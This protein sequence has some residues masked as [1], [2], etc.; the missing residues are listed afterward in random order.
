MKSKLILYRA[1]GYFSGEKLNEKTCVGDGVVFFESEERAFEQVGATGGKIGK[2]D[3]FSLNRSTLGALDLTE[4]DKIL[5]LIALA[6]KF[7]PLGTDS[8]FAMK[9]RGY[10]LDNYLTEVSGYDVIRCY[11]PSALMTF[12]DEFIDGEVSLEVLTKCICRKENIIYVLKTEKGL[13]RLKKISS[14]EVF[15][16][17]AKYA[18]RDLRLLKLYAKL[19]TQST[20]EEKYISDIMTEGKVYAGKSL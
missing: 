17:F 6:L 4:P 7:R 18:I 3:K 16:N 11:A 10:L 9:S 12:I 14:N 13:K 8:T 2:A 5:N 20:E 1:E 19:K 15:E